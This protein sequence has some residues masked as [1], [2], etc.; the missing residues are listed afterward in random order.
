MKR[1]I[2]CSTFLII[3]SLV[4]F[5][6]SSPARLQAEPADHPATAPANEH[7]VAPAWQNYLR[8]GP[9]EGALPDFSQAGYRY[10][11]KPIPHPAV[12]VSVADFGAI[13]N[14]GNDDRDAIQTAI[15]AVENMGGGVVYLPAGTYDL[16]CAPLAE[17][18]GSHPAGHGL[19]ITSSSVV[20]RGAGAAPDGTVLR[21]HHTYVTHSD[22][23]GLDYALVR[24]IGPGTKG[25]EAIA[26]VA[27]ARRGD[28]DIRVT[29]TEGLRAGQLLKLTL[30]DPKI[31][32]KAPHAAE[33]DLAQAL[34]EP[35]A[36]R[37]DLDV[38]LA[39]SG[40]SQCA[41]LVE[42]EAITSPTGLRLKQPLRLGVPLRW[43][44][45]LTSISTI[46]D[47]GIEGIRLESDWPGE[48]AH[49]KP[50]PRDIK[51][52]Y[53]NGGPGI[54]RTAEE[55][56]YAWSAIS[57]NGVMHGW[58]REVQ[59]CNYTQDITASR[60][61]CLTIESVQI[62][63]QKGHCGISFLR[64]FDS[65]VRD[66]TI[67]APRVHT[68][69]VSCFSAG[70]VFTRSQFN[71]GPYDET[72]EC[73]TCLDFHGLAP[74]ENL[75]DNILN[76]Y[77]YPGGALNYLPHAGVR[78]V[79]WNITAP[80]KMLRGGASGEFFRTYA[81]T[82]SGKPLS[83]HEHWPQSFVI[84]LHREGEPVVI[85][86]SAAD[87][88]DPWITVQGLNRPGVEPV[89]LYQAQVELAKRASAPKP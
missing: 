76:A 23:S 29:S 4:L 35:F 77:V 89:S 79:F 54:I 49:H 62:T 84:G 83:A 82:S 53:V 22:N 28:R 71:Y 56:N 61:K 8:T 52:D 55:Q 46:T 69:F 88:A 86:G 42:V 34:V 60:S 70:N 63:G 80:D 48:Y 12:S 2:F 50:F 7:W 78:N 67:T 31:D 20:L 11:Q 26:L 74:Y 43:A 17:S 14:D 47:V 25:K 45:A 32:P 1:Y 81:P 19:T 41:M 13:P 18:T 10:S 72:S 51:G 33:A 87:R 5:L 36:L 38:Y 75:Y 68:F 16:H 6:T 40:N 64:T 37:D 85:A 21:Q 15:N 57:F 59:T 3:L 27:E 65:L 24:F 73:D 66:I 58:V 30:T 9:T 44:P 39:Y